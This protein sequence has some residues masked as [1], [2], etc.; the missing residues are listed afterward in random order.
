MVSTDT[1]HDD[2]VNSDGAKQGTVAFGHDY[3]ARLEYSEK[4]TS[5]DTGPISTYNC[6]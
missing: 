4:D 6:G 3:L 2:T 5:K 1:G